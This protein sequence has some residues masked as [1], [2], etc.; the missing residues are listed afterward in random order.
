MLYPDFFNDLRWT[1]FKC[2]NQA[3]KTIAG[4]VV[5][6]IFR[7]NDAAVSQDN[8]HLVSEHGL[9]PER[10]G[11]IDF[12]FRVTQVSY[13]FQFNLFLSDISVNKF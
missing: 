9:V 1:F 5:Q 7:I 3:L 12:N 8:S 6:D 2:S 10:F 4:N 11:S 13:G